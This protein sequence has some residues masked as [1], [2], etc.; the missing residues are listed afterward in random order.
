MQR[1][2]AS[3]PPEV[4]DL[5]S[6]LVTDAL[7]AQ[8]AALALAEEAR[9]AREVVMHAQGARETDAKLD[10]LLASLRDALETIARTFGGE[11][12][13]L[14]Q[15]LLEELLPDGVAYFTSKP[16]VEQHAALRLLIEKLRAPGT[17]EA[18]RELQ[19]ERW[20]ERLDALNATYGELLTQPDH[21]PREQLKAADTR[22]YVA[23]AQVVAWS[24]GACCWA[25]S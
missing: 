11:E 3:Q 8:H 15:R 6:P 13:A 10:R 20:V 24:A 1:E 4:R 21:K 2:L 9:T 18:L 25:P 16:F 14:A 19:L 7:H 5:L 22:G 12:A 23:M 17:W